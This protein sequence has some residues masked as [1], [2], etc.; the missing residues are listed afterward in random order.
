MRKL[1]PG[2]MIQIAMQNTASLWV[3]L[4]EELASRRA[5]EPSG[6][7]SL[8]AQKFETAA[9]QVFQHHPGR[10]RDAL[11]I[12]GDIHQAAGADDDARRCFE[13]ALAVDSPEPAPRARLATKLAMLCEA[14]SDVSGARRYYELAIQLHDC[15]ENRSELSTLLNNL[16][17]LHRICEDGPKAIQTYC[18]ALAEAVA[19]H[20]P[21]HPEIALI[22]NNLGVAYTDQGDLSKAEEAH[23]RALQI[24]EEAYGANHPD[25]GQSLANLGVVYHA[26]GQHEKAERFYRSAMITLSHFVGAD[27]MQM[28]RIAANLGRLP[29]VHARS[30]SKTTRL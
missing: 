11:E 18:R 27:D 21:H 2:A 13:D 23:L 3:L 8:A 10:L 25:V 5:D 26:R 29:H 12:T 28:Q 14:I 16:A 4:C 20:G 22:A 15:G 30:L 1:R 6:Q 19:A 17:G 9:R 7:H 24:R